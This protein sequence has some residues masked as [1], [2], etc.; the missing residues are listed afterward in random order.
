LQHEAVADHADIRAVAENFAQP[1]E[2][3]GAVA[4]QL[5]HALRQRHV[6]PLAEL[7]E[8]DCD[9]LSFFS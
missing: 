7:G 8:A 6:Q 3:V 5:L 1:A 9:S 2:E 4:R